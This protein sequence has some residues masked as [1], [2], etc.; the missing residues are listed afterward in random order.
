[1][2][3]QNS[4]SLRP[5]DGLTFRVLGIAR[6]STEHQ[7]KRSLDD[8]KNLYLEWLGKNVPIPFEL[9]MI[10][11][12]GS[13]ENITREEYHR[14]INLVVTGRFDLVL[15]EDLGRISRRF[16]SQ[17][18]CELCED[19]DTRLVAINDGIDTQDENWRLSASFA[20]IRHELYNAD[21]SKRIRRTLRNRFQE[22]GVIGTLPFGII[23]PKDVNNDSGLVKDLAAQEIYDEI[24]RLLE[25]GAGYS[26]V[27]DWLN[28]R[29]I[30]TSK[31]ARSRKWTCALVSGLIH[32]PILAGKRI[33]NRK[34]T[35]RVNQTGKHRSVPA[36]PSLTLYRDV[37]HLAFIEWERWV[38]LVKMLDRRN[39][40]FRRKG[41]CGAD[42]RKGIPRKRTRWPGQHVCCG[43]CGRLFVY[44]GHGIKDKMMCSGAKNYNCWNGITLNGPEA[45]QKMLKAI[46]TE[47][48][49]LPDF[50]KAFE[51]KIEEA[52]HAGREVLE[53]NCLQMK[54]KISLIRKKIANIMKAIEDF[55]GTRELLE[56]LKLLGSEMEQLEEQHRIETLKISVPAVIPNMAQIREKI[57]ESLMKYSL[58][59]QELAR[60]LRAIIPRIHVF[61]FYLVDS[62]KPVLRARISINLTTFFPGGISESALAGM[63]QREITVDLFDPPERVLILQKVVDYLPEGKTL[64]SI[65]EALGVPSYLVSRTNALWL[66]M[67]ELGV[68]D[69]YQV[70]SEP[71]A[72]LSKMRRHLH[73]RYRFVPLDSHGSD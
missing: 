62:G 32:N 26:E 2:S 47:I 12:Q 35:K 34:V 52:F 24:F 1:M 55:G 60:A 15:V 41:I 38:N 11:G 73:P 40:C 31:H 7:D 56:Q 25:G 46:L 27:A 16:H 20:T 13:G 61:P 51:C 65:A 43:I 66:K 36:D 58:E 30:P 57:S 17:I 64:C 63:F 49:A 72:F 22:G 5:K 71:S 67:Q 53:K 44:G 6:I 21:T 37:P 3:L 19:C 18:F 8:Q 14:A 68:S 54:S 9:E 39:A 48:Q 23:R 33:R 45:G 10:S 70:L 50:E 29:N 59:S 4:N 28:K 69:P 42:T